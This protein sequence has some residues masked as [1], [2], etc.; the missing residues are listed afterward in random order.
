[1]KKLKRRSKVILQTGMHRSGTSLLAK[2]LMT[3]GV[4]MGKD[5]ISADLDNVKGFYEDRYVVDLHKNFLQAI[6]ADPNHGMTIFGEIDLS[7]APVTDA[8]K[9]LEAFIHKRCEEEVMWGVKDPRLCLLLSIWL[10]T[11]DATDVQPLSVFSLRNPLDVALSLENRNGFTIEQGLLM[12]L[13]YV[14]SFACN[15]GTCP[16]LIVSYEKLLHDPSRELERVAEFIEVDFKSRTNNVEEYISIFVDSGL[17]HHRSSYG[18]LQKAAENFPEV[19]FVYDW[20]KERADGDELSSRTWNEVREYGSGLDLAQKIITNL[21]LQD[22]VRLTGSPP[23]DPILYYD[24]GGDF[25]E[26]EVLQAT[27]SS[28]IG[29]VVFDL[30]SI[31]NIKRLRFDPC[32]DVCVLRVEEMTVTDFNGRSK[33]IA[34]SYSNALFCEDDLYGFNT[35]DPQLYYDV[36]NDIRE[37]F[38]S[39]QFD[40]IGLSAMPRIVNELMAQQEKISQSA[41][42]EKA[43]IR[44]ENR[45]LQKVLGGM[46]EK[47]RDVRA[48]LESSRFDTVSARADLESS[49]S[50]TAAVRADLESSRSDTA[51][52]RADL[53]SSRSDTAAVRADLESSRFDTVSARA[54]LESSR[55]DTAAV[56]ADLESSRFDTAAVRADLESSRFD[57]AAV[58]ADLESSRF[59]TVSARADLESSRADIAA[60][61]ADLESSRSDIAAVRADLESSRS[62]TVAA[63]AGLEATRVELTIARSETKEANVQANMAWGDVDIARTERRIAQTG[64]I[65]AWRR[66]ALVQGDLAQAI[67]D[68]D[69]A[70]RYIA[71]IRKSI[72]WRLT[73]PL[74]FVR[75]LIAG[76]FRLFFA[77]ITFSPTRLRRVLEDF[78][79]SPVGAFFYSLLIPNFVKKRINKGWRKG[80]KPAESS[81]PF[82]PVREGGRPEL[83]E[84]EAPETSSPSAIEALAFYLPQ[85]HPIPEND[86]WWGEGFTEW[87]NVTKTLPMYPGHDQPKHPGSMGYYD[88]R[89]PEV[90]KQQAEL[91]K[92]FGVHGFCFHHYDFSG[93]RILETPVDNFIANPDI[94]IPF[95]LCWANEN[96]TRRW[97]GFDQDI[98]LSQNHSPEDDVRFINSMVPYFAD[99]RYIRKDG[100]PFFIVY[101]AEQ[102]PDMA[103]TLQRWRDRW[104]ELYGEGLYLV[105]AQS[106]GAEDPRDYGF[107]AAVQFP[108]HKYSWDN[109]RL[110]DQ[111]NVVPDYDGQIFDYEHFAKSY[112]SVDPEYV[113]Y[114]TV[115]PAWDNTA[116]RGV[117]GTIFAN[118]NPSKYKKWLDLA[119]KWTS[120]KHPSGSQF[121]FINAW[122]EWAE[123][124][125]LEPDRTYGYAYLNATSQVLAEY[126]KMRATKDLSTGKILFVSHDAYLGGAQK[127]LLSL[128]Q[129]LSTHTSLQIYTLCLRGGPFMDD[130]AKFGPATTAEELG[131]GPS[132]ENDL[133]DKVQMFCGGKLDLIY[134]NTVVAGR[135]YEELSKFKVPIITHVHELEESIRVYASDYIADVISHT[136]NFIACSPAVEAN[137]RSSYSVPQA[138]IDLICAHIDPVAESPSVGRKQMLREKLGLPRDSKIVLGCGL[139]LFWRKGADLFIEVAKKVVKESYEKVAFYWV[140]GF[141]PAQAHDEHGSWQDIWDAMEREGLA[142]LVHFIGQQPNAVEYIE[143]SDIFLLP[144]R[145]DPY[146]L[147]CLEAAERSVP[148]VCFDK[149]GGM[150]GFVGDDCGFVVPWG[151]VDAMAEK[152]VSL[153][154]D[155]DLLTRLG[156]QARN[157][158][159]FRHTA[160][161]VGPAILEVIREVGGIAP[162]VSIIVPN[163]NKKDYLVER[164][165]SVFNQSYKD[166]EVILLDDCSTDGSGE[167]L[168]QYSNRSN[169]SFIQNVRNKGVFAQWAKGI[170][171]A[172]GEF[173]WIAEADDSCSVDFL[174]K[175]IPAFIDEGV[176]ISYSESLAIDA[177][178]DYLFQYKNMEYLKEL[179]HT[180]WNTSYVV[181]AK[182]EVECSL[183]YRNT[184]PNVSAVVFRKFDCSV[185][186]EVAKDMKLAGDWVFYLYAMMNGSVSYVK[187]P[188]NHHRRHDDTCTA[189][190]ENSVVR[191]K[192]VVMAQ[193]L[194][195]S[196]YD[197][198]SDS[199]ACCKSYAKNIWIELG[200]NEDGFEAEYAG[201]LG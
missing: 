54:D 193:N 178:S 5:F 165:D 103:G 45:E 156:V 173:I 94:D 191:F 100:K 72:S 42:E 89:L 136:T 22:V 34:P 185:W 58:R 11:L 91:A 96:W 154:Q 97:D 123:G 35:T 114:K 47:I 19:M 32:E 33:K 62:D 119:S 64:A 137:M 65:E 121:V 73:A 125:Y 177:N 120:S 143:A 26:N 59:D 129:W 106:F 109:P 105:M 128:L 130:F 52:V 176:R 157:K 29:S 53:E 16:S 118:S 139:G 190:T 179:S 150:P 107:D 84:T 145:E 66:H 75:I 39:F 99:S 187:E 15:V 160:D 87:T 46:Q 141:D 117:C 48:D 161:V 112:S 3:L 36:G 159:L 201:I 144:S 12:W 49:R 28:E 138:A 14:Y 44:G 81:T 13:E 172:K 142:D 31:S 78:R 88:L 132:G 111:L 126:P 104:D 164:L 199:A 2:G 182:Q 184:I 10:Q 169:V 135:A 171:L 186:F 77:L 175:L 1:M 63:R 122:N 79:W 124:A 196:L 6:G 60:V 57:T 152:T 17:Q 192:E 56:R 20:L 50:D 183:A 98:L 188:L 162:V 90:M 85:F 197:L 158:L 37:V 149:A 43:L 110:N 95:C 38:F 163:Y 189:S 194:A 180:K 115:S 74:R 83:F 25:S 151:D 174:K 153:L 51:A 146:P 86:E 80:Q 102:F 82:L 55:S 71:A 8:I 140:G 69:A 166:F 200:L 93:R 68:N 181:D 147:V 61:R 170:E 113:L 108:P 40:A 148:I 76:S 155:A 24:T 133:A 7:K 195:C 134:G 67:A 18:D 21:P 27:V 127:V 4:H 92:K 116:R 41:K 131:C 167:I 30:S 168:E 9:A 101:K 198:D 70:Q 23:L